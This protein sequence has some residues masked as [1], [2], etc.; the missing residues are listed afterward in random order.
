VPTQTLSAP[1]L[2]AAVAFLGQDTYSHGR[3]ALTV[4]KKG[5]DG[6]YASGY[7]NDRSCLI[8]KNFCG[9]KEA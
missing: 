3:S 6:K 1:H 8:I 9:Y 7:S 4:V 5:R 2:L